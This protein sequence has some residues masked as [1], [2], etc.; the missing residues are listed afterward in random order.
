MI[1]KMVVSSKPARD[2]YRGEYVLFRDALA[3]EDKGKIWRVL[4]PR[5]HEMEFAKI[6][7]IMKI[8]DE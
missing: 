5:K 3:V 4:L 7:W 1:V 8:L 2:C 6:N